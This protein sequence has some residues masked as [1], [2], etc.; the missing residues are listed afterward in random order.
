[1]F[2]LSAEVITADWV[3]PPR[4]IK[5]EL[6][7]SEGLHKMEINASFQDWEHVLTSDMIPSP[8][9]HEYKIRVNAGIVDSTK[10]SWSK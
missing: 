3:W 8:P 6:N 9:Q 10:V 4:N 7:H 2:D 5:D 1:M